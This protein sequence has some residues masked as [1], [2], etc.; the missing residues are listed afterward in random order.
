[1]S[2]LKCLQIGAL[3]DHSGVAMR[4]SKSKDCPKVTLG[5]ILRAIIEEAIGVVNI[6]GD[7]GELK[8]PW[9]DRRDWK[10][11]NCQREGDTSVR[12]I[13]IHVNGKLGGSLCQHH[14][15]DE[16][17][18]GNTVD[19]NGWA[20]KRDRNHCQSTRRGEHKR[21][22]N[23]HVESRLSL[24]SN[25]NDMPGACAKGE[26]ASKIAK[27]ALEKGARAREGKQGECSWQKLRQQYIHGL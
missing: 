9:T 8:N 27:S 1:M 4:R 23:C 10:Y 20:V 11:V 15:E 6:P 7:G 3:V 26:I 14:P 13:G 22:D 5:N 17:E 19:V 2:D 12:G 25:A 24:F 18:D 21:N 16:G